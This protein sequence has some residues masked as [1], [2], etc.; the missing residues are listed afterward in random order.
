MIPRSQPPPA[1]EDTQMG[2]R[3]AAERDGRWTAGPQERRVEGLTRDAPR[4]CILAGSYG[5]CLHDPATPT[6]TTHAGRG[7]PRTLL[8]QDRRTP[9]H[10]L[11]SSSVPDAGAGNCEAGA[12]PP[13]TAHSAVTATSLRT[14][15][16]P[17]AYQVT[18]PE[19]YSRIIHRNQ[20]AGSSSKCTGAES[21]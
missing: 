17:G 16:L 15:R 20:K 5:Q 18:G 6:S 7:Q 14:A 12:R 3:R 4:D 21:W 10:G 9:R 19:A 13:V 2:E 8:S 1:A 11:L